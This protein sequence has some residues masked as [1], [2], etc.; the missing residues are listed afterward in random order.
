MPDLNATEEL[1]NPTP[2][3]KTEQ[4]INNYAET[5]DPDAG[6]DPEELKLK[7]DLVG[8][9]NKFVP[10]EH[11][12][13]FEQH[14]GNFLNGHKKLKIN[15]MPADANNK[16]MQFAVQNAKEPDVSPATDI[17]S[18]MVKVSTD[19]Q[20]IQVIE[21]IKD[22]PSDKLEAL[23]KTFRYAG[24]LKDFPQNKIK[25]DYPYYVWM[26]QL[27][28]DKQNLVAEMLSDINKTAETPVSETEIK[29]PAVPAATI[30][31]TIPPAS[32]S[33][34]SSVNMGEALLGI[35]K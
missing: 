14:I 32:G 31:N 2:A 28:E 13:E 29:K 9:L 3:D 19:P 11:Q 22:L 8:N 10:Q 6:T 21:D 25:A 35:T 30:K 20:K 26:A 27:P 4:Q 7:D 5:D 24:I 17:H 23:K 1:N 12:S 18:K 16:A 33:K 34:T 15:K